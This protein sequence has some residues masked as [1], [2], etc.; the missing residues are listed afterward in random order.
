MM[1]AEINVKQLPPLES[2]PRKRKRQTS[3]TRKSCCFAKDAFQTLNELRKKQLLCDFKI[4]TGKKAHEVHRSVLVTR[5][6]YFHQFFTI[7]PLH[8][9]INFAES[10]DVGVQSCVEFMYTNDI[11]VTIENVEEIFNVSLAFQLDSVSTMCRDCLMNNLTVENCL[12]IR[13]IAERFKTVL[14]NKFGITDLQ[15]KAE[16][17]AISN[18]QAV[19]D[20]EPFLKAPTK[21]LIRILSFEKSTVHIWNSISRWVASDFQTRRH[22][23]LSILKSLK[24]DEFSCQDLLLLTNNKEFMVSPGVAEFL[25]YEILKRGNSAPTA[26]NWLGLRDLAVKFNLHDLEVK[27]NSFVFENFAAIAQSLNFCKIDK[28]TLSYFLK[29]IGIIKSRERI[30][31]DAIINWTNYHQGRKNFFSD[32][33]R[34]IDLSSF[35]VEFIKNTVKNEPLISQDNECLKLVIEALCLRAH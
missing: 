10:F 19:I 11:S 8:K 29:G 7:N 18:F 16:K 32:V 28:N 22:E 24:M 13:R 17:F 2:T 34:S 20:T 21:E 31:W 26:E 5:S 25:C 6:T 1:S 15:T 23:L 35:S 27:V 4:N 3:K 9:E 33:I 14:L 12:I 30:I